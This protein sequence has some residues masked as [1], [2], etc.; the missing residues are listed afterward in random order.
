MDFLLVG[1]LLWGLL[2][3]AVIL[4]VVGLW[5]NEWKALLWSGLSFLP[6]MLLI[7]AGDGGFLFKLALLV[8]VAVMAGAFWMKNRMMYFM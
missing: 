5:K 7:A 4:L 1:F 3:A 8:P 6:P 2:I